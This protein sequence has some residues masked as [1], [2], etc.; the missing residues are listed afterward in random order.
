MEEQ[1]DKTVTEWMRKQVRCPAVNSTT[2]CAED[3]VQEDVSRDM[4][5][6][7]LQAMPWH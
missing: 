7:R 3:M 2:S 4:D 5:R 1:D 6:F